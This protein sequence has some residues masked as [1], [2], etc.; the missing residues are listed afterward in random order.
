MLHLDFRVADLD[1]EHDGAVQIGARF[2]ADESPEFRVY[3]DPAGHPFCLC[4]VHW[5]PMPLTRQDS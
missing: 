4:A 5:G 2:L 1:A 3:A